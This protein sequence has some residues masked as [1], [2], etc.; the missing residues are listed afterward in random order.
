MPWQNK[1]TRK[2]V[3]KTIFF[4]LFKNKDKTRKKITT[5]YFNAFNKALQ[6]MSPLCYDSSILVP[7]EHNATECRYLSLPWFSKRLPAIHI[8]FLSIWE[9]R[10]EQSRRLL[11][12]TEVHCPHSKREWG[13][14]KPTTAFSL[15]E[16]L[17]SMGK[18]GSISMQ[19][20]KL[21]FPSLWKHKTKPTPKRTNPN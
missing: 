5:I 1:Q 9:M 20:C 11:Q 16:S 4:F 18:I 2:P 14:G 6:I 13:M 19:V 7:N 17:T 15:A 12:P 21:S 10:M 3:L 8:Q